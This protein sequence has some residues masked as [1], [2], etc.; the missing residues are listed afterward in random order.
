M[1]Q[2]LSACFCLL[3]SNGF[4]QAQSLQGKVRGFLSSLCLLQCYLSKACKKSLICLNMVV[5]CWWFPPKG[6][7]SALEFSH[8]ERTPKPACSIDCM[9]CALLKPHCLQIH[10]LGAFRLLP[11]AIERT[12]G[13]FKTWWMLSGW[14]LGMQSRN[15][16]SRQSN[17]GSSWNSMIF[18]DIYIYYYQLSQLALDLAG[19]LADVLCC[20]SHLLWIERE[21]ESHKAKGPKDSWRRLTGKHTMRVQSITRR[22]LDESPSCSDGGM[23]CLSPWLRSVFQSRPDRHFLLSQHKIG[24]NFTWWS[25]TVITRNFVVDLWPKRKLLAVHPSDPRLVFVSIR[26]MLRDLLIAKGLGCC[27]LQSKNIQ[28]HTLK[29]FVRRPNQSSWQHVRKLLLLSLVFKLSHHAFKSHLRQSECTHPR[30]L[31]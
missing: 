7:P 16:K 22:P 24:V 30:R 4:S 17:F 10:W 26:G 21:R 18:N 31:F 8:T 15:G 27:L 25:P 19:E 9:W 3:N 2:P 23:L 12:H 29:L 28:E 5:Q 20:Q 11:T 1:Q 13:L 14:R 6:H